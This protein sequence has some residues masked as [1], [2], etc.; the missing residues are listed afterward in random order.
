MR[1]RIHITRETLTCLGGAYKVEPGRGYERDPFLRDHNIETFF[2]V[3]SPEVAGGSK[4]GRLGEESFASPVK[5]EVISKE[6]RLM[7]HK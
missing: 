2:I 3:P 1:R 7:G 6:M 4:V 5:E